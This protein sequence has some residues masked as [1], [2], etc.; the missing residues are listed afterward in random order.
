MRLCADL[1]NGSKH[2]RLTSPRVDP[3]TKIGAKVVSLTL[4][5]NLG[6]PRDMPPRIL[7][8]YEVEAGGEHHDAFT[9]AR[10]CMDD[11]EGYLRGN[12]LI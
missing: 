8:K 12:G 9:L 6:P 4:H 3:D 11:W 7:V 2:L 1:C 10:A 5:A